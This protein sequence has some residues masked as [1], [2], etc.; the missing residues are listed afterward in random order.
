MNPVVHEELKKL[1]GLGWNDPR[2]SCQATHEDDLSYPDSGFKTLE[3]AGAD[4]YWYRHRAYVATRI[5]HRENIRLIWDVG[6]GTG[7][8][9]TLF[10]LENIDVISVEPHSEGARLIR[11]KTLER[12]QLSLEQIAL[13]SQSIAAVSLFDVIEHIRD[14]LPTLSEVRRV[15]QPDG[16]CLVTVPACKF[17]WSDEDVLAG[18]FRRYSR[19]ELTKHLEDSGFRVLQM[20]FIFLPL[21]PLAFAMRVIPFRL[22]NRKKEG[23]APEQCIK[24]LRPNKVVDKIATLL[25]RSEYAASKVLPIPFGLSLIALA[26]PNPHKIP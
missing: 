24:H 12:F 21:V 14:P 13:P 2:S 11:E 18:H 17:L 25:L 6:A 16:K 26:T 1:H 9:A 8:M 20:H 7:T 15:L 23:L 3:S 10:S 5:L 19:K 4:G 22:G